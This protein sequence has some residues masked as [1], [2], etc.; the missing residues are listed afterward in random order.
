M[1]IQFSVANFRSFKDRQTL[2]LVQAKG[3]ELEA[4]N[5]FEPAARIGHRLLKSAAIYGPNAS[6]KSN[7][8]RALY[9]M[10]Q[11]IMESAAESQRGD[12]LPITPFLL[13][14]ATAQSP[15][16]FEAVF[17][18]GDVRYQYGFSATAER[19]MNEWLYAFP[20]GRQQHWYTRT[21][22]DETRSYAWDMGNALAGDKQLWKKATR[23]NALLLSTAVQLN[24]DALQPVYDWFRDTLCTPRSID[25]NF[26]H[27]A[28]KYGND[29]QRGKLLSFLKSADFDIHD[30][31]VDA[32][33]FSEHLLPEDM[34]KAI[35]S[36]MSERF[37]DGM[38]YDV[39]TAHKL[40]DGTTVLFNMADESLGTQGFFALSG[41]VLDVLENGRVLLVDDLQD[42][43]HPMLSRFVLSQFHGSEAN[44]S[45]A[46]LIF[47][48]HETSILTQE[49]IRRD[50]VWFCEKDA[51]QASR[52][53]PLTDFS[54]RKDRE[55]LEAAYLSGRYGALPYFKQAGAG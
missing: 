14:K 53:Y 49:I 21:W 41:P 29:A 45:N 27:T 19:V 13:D 4:R 32:R 35:R 23:D 43:F 47:S 36:E 42:D 17:A 52:L 38:I 6:G 8:L 55:N 9:A 11:I 7:L 12:L 33:K 16:E 24:S 3:R 54:P 20:K 2:S 48:T 34:P 10:K 22:H 1:L 30:V 25:P 51:A 37:K 46:Q 44:P 15:S 26:D 31:K 18:A 5:T 50:Q 28:S 39:H 40:P